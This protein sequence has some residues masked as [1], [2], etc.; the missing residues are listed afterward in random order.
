MGRL[1]PLV[2]LQLAALGRQLT[3]RPAES[4]HRLEVIVDELASLGRLPILED[5][6]AFF[7]GYGARCVLLLQDLAQLHKLYGLRETIT[8]NCR[9]HLLTANQNPATRRH[10]SSLAGTTTA[11]Y[12]RTTRAPTGRS[13]RPRAAAP[14]P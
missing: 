1:A 6:L 3:E 11:R 9:V 2:R 13:P 5:L 14:S 8:G 12:R 10:A 7:R 4:P